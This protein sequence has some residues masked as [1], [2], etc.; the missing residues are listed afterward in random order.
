MYKYFLSP[1]KTTM[2][3][4]PQMTSITNGS[5]VIISV[6]ASGPFVINFGDGKK[7]QKGPANVDTKFIHKYAIV[8]TKYDVTVSPDPDDP[9]AS[10]PS[11]TINVF[12]QKDVIIM[13]SNPKGITR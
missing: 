12:P 6:Y 3:A 1:I 9:S 13:P 11:K 4:P 2:S 5:R 8:S 7:K 10:F